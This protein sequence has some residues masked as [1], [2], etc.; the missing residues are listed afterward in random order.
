MNADRRGMDGGEPACARFDAVL[1]ELIGLDG[2]ESTISP[3]E[4]EAL[5]RHAQACSR[6]ADSRRA[7]AATV[8]LL[9][10]LP[11]KNAPSDFLSWVREDLPEAGAGTPAI[12]R[13][14]LRKPWIAIAAA[15]PFLAAVIYLATLEEKRP[16]PEI[17]LAPAAPPPRSSQDEEGE[18][19][20]GKRALP[21]IAM[22]PAL[23]PSGDSPSRD[24]AVSG[25]R[26]VEAAP[27]L[28]PKLELRKLDAAK[29]ADL[30]RFGQAAS[31]SS[32]A[33]EAIVLALPY[34]A[35]RWEADVASFERE[36]RG[37]F[38]DP[39]R[40]VALATRRSVPSNV[41]A[42]RGGAPP[43]PQSRSELDASRKALTDRADTAIVVE[44]QASATAAPAAREITISVDPAR[45]PDLRSFVETWSAPRLRAQAREVRQSPT[46]LPLEEKLEASPGPPVTVRIRVEPLLPPP[47]RDPKSP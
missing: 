10:G 21:E 22:A 44:R 14:R 17:A 26:A 38:I 40:N 33:A 6:C 15:V 24:R 31:G 45:L 39:A 25:D 36:V 29:D 41:G 7:Y 43:A 42:V 2:E 1:P 47:S 34:T 5:L 37:R 9:R 18:A 12:P 35:G 13:H 16:T 46:E 11:R 32:T 23:S 19:A 8:D 4:K 27:P 20:G 28:E 3:V 30:A